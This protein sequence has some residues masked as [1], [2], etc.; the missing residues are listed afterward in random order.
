MATTIIEFE[1]LSAESKEMIIKWKSKADKLDSLEEQIGRF[2][3]DGDGNELEDGEG[4][5]LCDMGEVTA[6][7]LGFL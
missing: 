6:R 4:G 5:D 3:F 2:Y 1:T 7:A